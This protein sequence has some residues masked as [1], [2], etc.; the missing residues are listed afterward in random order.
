MITFGHIGPASCQCS[1]GV[2][3]MWFIKDDRVVCSYCDRSRTMSMPPQGVMKM[4]CQCSAG[5][6]ATWFVTAN[7]NY[8]C[9]YCERTR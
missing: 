1:K 8:I 2:D 7:G 3:A 4:P 5:D 9:S 6:E